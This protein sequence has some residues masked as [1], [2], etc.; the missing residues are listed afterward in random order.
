VEVSI[1]AVSPELI[2]EANI[3]GDDTAVSKI[4]HKFNNFI[5]FSL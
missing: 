5:F 3:A 1:Q 4:K 2:S